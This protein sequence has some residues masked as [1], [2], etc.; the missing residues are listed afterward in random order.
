MVEGVY[1]NTV[2]NTLQFVVL[3]HDGDTAKQLH[4]LINGEFVAIIPDKQGNRQVYGTQTGLHCT[5]A[6]RELY[7]DDTLSG[8]LV[9]MT[10]EGAQLPFLNITQVVYNSLLTPTAECE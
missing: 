1:V 10:E 7:N 4:A 5:G 9:T 2:T 6:L 8:W 3:K